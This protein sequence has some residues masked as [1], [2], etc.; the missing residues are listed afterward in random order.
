V[1][2]CGCV[3]LVFLAVPEGCLG[4]FCRISLTICFVGVKR[5]RRRRGGERPA[6]GGGTGGFRPLQRARTASRSRSYR[7]EPVRAVS[8]AAHWIGPELG[9]DGGGLS[10]RAT[11]RR[12][13]K[14]KRR[15]D[16]RRRVSQ[17]S[18][19]ATEPGWPAKAMMR[20]ARAAVGR[21]PAS[22]RAGAW[23]A[24]GA[25]RGCPGGIW[26]LG[27]RRQGWWL[28]GSRSPSSAASARSGGTAPYSEQD[29]RLV[30]LD[31]RSPLPEPGDARRGPRP[32][33][34]RLVGR[35]ATQDVDGI[36]L[37]PRARG[38]RRGARLPAPGR[39]SAGSNGVRLHARHRPESPGR[40]EPRQVGEPGHGAR[41]GATLD[42]P[43]EVEFQSP[44]PLRTPWLR[45]RLPQPAQGVVLHSGDFKLDLTPVD[46]RRTDLARHRPDLLERRDQA[47]PVR[48]DECPRSRAFHRQR[49]FRGESRSGD[50][51]LRT[52]TAA[53]SWRAS[54]V[55]S[56]HPAA[57]QRP[58]SPSGRRN[59]PPRPVDGETSPLAK[60]A[61]L[62]AGCPDP[63][64][65]GHREDR[66]GS[67]RDGLCIIS[68]GS[69]GEPDGPALALMATPARAAWL[70]VTRWRRRPCSS[71]H[72][73]PG[74]E[75]AVAKVDGRAGPAG[76]PT[77]STPAP[78]TVHESG[79]R[80][81]RASWR[82]LLSIAPA[83]ARFIPRPRGEY[84]HLLRHFAGSPSR[85]ASPRAR[86]PRV[87]GRGPHSP[88]HDDG[89]DLRRRGVGVLRLRRRQSRR[90]FGMGVPSRQTRGWARRGVVVAV[91]TAGTAR[92]VSWSESRR[93]S[94][95]AS[96]PSR[97][98]RGSSPEEIRAGGGE[99]RRGGRRFRAPVIPERHAAA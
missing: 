72:A 92:P 73:I 46:G 4:S 71:S 55:T 38:P 84:R 27:G 36:V 21:V 39:A 20:G 76:C 19:G 74:N 89:I 68:T 7:W 94:A 87:R 2:G 12:P 49:A 64:D 33:R 17:S 78:P 67:S 51:F 44:S 70:S 6:D 88:L 62:F 69:Q 1:F 41:R 86:F 14:L 54:P 25:G 22:S 56:S 35:A 75:W 81:V 30:V 77:S 60:G 47:A 65:G 8:V 61:G 29:G 52:V 40:G 82:R 98:N 79:S 26:R 97:G 80:P 58:P 59:R 42:R 90:R 34:P 37:T 13:G 3:L 28:R 23:L 11:S 45:R 48:F 66:R 15:L 99:G 83:P 16:R 85:W 24:R 50:L 32:A 93:S 10:L 63:S 31:L 53:S 5:R 91:A 95:G 18:D 57:G 43:F 96:S 9:H